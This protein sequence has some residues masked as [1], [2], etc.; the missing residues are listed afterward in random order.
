MLMMMLCLNESHDIL[1]NNQYNYYN[2]Y[3]TMYGVCGQIK[4]VQFDA[5]AE[6]LKVEMNFNSCLFT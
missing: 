2:Y 3:N 5:A 4:S 1:V 6:Q